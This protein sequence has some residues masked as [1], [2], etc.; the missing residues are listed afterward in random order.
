MSKTKKWENISLEDIL[1]VDPFD[2]QVY[3]YDP[4]A[5][6]KCPMISD[7]REYFTQIYSKPLNNKLEVLDGAQHVHA[8]LDIDQWFEDLDSTKNSMVIFIEGYAGCGKSTFVQY[9]LVHQLKTYNYEYEYYNYD[10]GAYYDNRN[11]HRILSAIRECFIKQFSTC[12]LNHDDKIIKRFVELL[13][14]Q[15]INRLD[16]SLD[17]YNE[18]V[19]TDTFKQAI[20]YLLDNKKEDRFRSAMHNQLKDFS[21]E[22]ILALDYVFRLAR[23]IESDSHDNSVLYI[24][25]DNMD[26]IEN[27]DELNA[28]DNTLVSLRKNIDD[29]INIT[30]DNYKDI[31]TPQFVIIATYRKITAAK[32]D[33]SSYS[34]RIDDYSEYNNFIQYVDASHVY[35]YFRIINKRKEYFANYI[36]R[37]Q[38][39]GGKVLNKLEIADILTNTEF[40]HNRYAGLWNNNYRTCSSILDKILRNYF[41]EAKICTDFVLIN[42]DGYD[43]TNSTYYGAS[44]IF[45][46]LVCKIFNKGGLWGSDHMNLIPLKVLNENKDP[47][48][49]TSLSR[50]ILTYISNSKD[51]SG[52]NRPVTTLEIFLEFEDLF[53]VDDVC[54]CLSNM[55]ARDKTDTWRRPIYYYRNA[56]SDNEKLKTALKK[57]WKL[58]KSEGVDASVD[59]TELLLCECGYAFIER[60]TSEFEFFSNR[61]SNSNQ[62]LYLVSNIDEIKRIINDVYDAVA[63]CCHDMVEFSKRYMKIKNIPTYEK[64][65]KLPIHPR[66]KGGNVQLHTERII[67]SHISYLN[68]CRLYYINLY[69]D[70]EKKKEVN[71]IFVSYIK[72]YLILY[73]EN[74]CPINSDRTKVAEELKSIIKEIETGDQDKLFLSISIHSKKHC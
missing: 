52:K 38:L 5:S 58:S 37:R 47:R 46:S 32:V 36:K 43:E 41:P 28:F 18:F 30:T 62:C 54:Q 69:I 71:N 24:C 70:L 1:R 44:A 73:D 17:I 19:N 55:L 8:E 22:Q 68:Y 60:L 57:Q 61:L 29:Y 56:L 66:T 35:S 53:P 27:F 16:T 39:N 23:Y 9:L 74:I 20:L 64:Y 12:I 2:Q 50:L 25:Y 11:S 21:I 31:P 65:N 72:Q 34:E 7:N 15:E 6:V 51:N 67:F 42:L 63:T 49:L 10:I 13:A 33:L 48:E 14:Q 26:A 45:L 4:V 3:I 40:V 59:Y